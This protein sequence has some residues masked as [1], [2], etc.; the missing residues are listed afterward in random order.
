MLTVAE[1][2]NK[3]LTLSGTW[4]FVTVLPKARS[5][6]ILIGLSNSSFLQVLWPNFCMYFSYSH[7]WHIPS[8]FIPYDLTIQR[9]LHEKYKLWNF[10]PCNFLKPEYN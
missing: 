2:D 4:R 5:I 9:I 10:S 8:Y 6:L 7:A 3:F 1:R